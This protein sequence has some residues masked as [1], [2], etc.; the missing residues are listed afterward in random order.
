MYQE[1]GCSTEQG[2]VWGN[3]SFSKSISWRAGKLLWGSFTVFSTNTAFEAFTSLKKLRCLGG[4][5]SFSV[6][7]AKA[8]RSSPKQDPGQSLNCQ[9]TLEGPCIY[10][11]SHLLGLWIVQ[12][13]LIR[14]NMV[15]DKN[16]LEI[17]DDGKVVMHKINFRW[18]INTKKTITPLPVL[19]RRDK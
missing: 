10:Y 11:I 6:G 15:Q 9:T 13:W 1:G 2:P 18:Q 16:S 14:E 8:T 17:T 7:E 12:I 4:A 5:S 3:C 19:S